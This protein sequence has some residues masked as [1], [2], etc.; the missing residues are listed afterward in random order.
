MNRFLYLGLIFLFILTGG[1]TAEEAEVTLAK[2]LNELLQVTQRSSGGPA[3]AEELEPVLRRR[4]G[5]DFMTRRAI[6][7]GWRQLSPGQR[8]EATELFTKLIIRRY[9]DQFT[10][11]EQPEFKILRVNSPAPGKAEIPTSLIYKGSRYKITYRME[12]RNGWLITDI[13][14]EGVS[15]I[16]NYRS[17]FDSL[18]KKRGVDS[19]MESLRSSVERL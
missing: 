18:Y 10:P 14:A 15:L 1:A 11:G 4:I 19:V 9:S 17:Q 16:S 12:D 3:M 13:L 7:P 2:G 6:G 8:T 5:F